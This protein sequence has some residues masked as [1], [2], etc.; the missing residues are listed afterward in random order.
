MQDSLIFVKIMASAL[1]KMDL[2]FV[3]ALKVTAAPNAR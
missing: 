2:L 3:C 1:I